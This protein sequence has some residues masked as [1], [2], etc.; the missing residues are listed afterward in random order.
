MKTFSVLVATVALAGVLTNARATDA[1]NQLAVRATSGNSAVADAAVAQLRTLG[2]RGVDLMAAA[3]PERVNEASHRAVLDRVCRQKDCYASR[4]FWYTDFDE[5]KAA[6]KASGKPIL[7][8]HLLGN[9]DEELSC[10]NSRFF[11]TT[12][13]SSQS[14]AGYMRD[15]FILHWQSV[16]PAPKV[17]VDF[18]DGRTLTQTITGN[19]IHYFLD[20][21]GRPLDAL[22]GLY[23]PAAFL[24]NLQRIHSMAADYI[25]QASEDR[26]QFA[27][28]Y[29][30]RE[31]TRITQELGK[32]LMRV[33]Q[34]NSKENPSARDASKLA[35][36]KFIGELPLLSAFNL[37]ENPVT[38]EEWERFAKHHAG[39]TPVV[40]DPASIEL[41][42]TK[43]SSPAAFGRLLRN[44]ER[45]VAEDTLRNEY[46][47]H[48]RLHEWLAADA[49]SIEALDERVYTQLFLTPPNDPWLGLLRD[50]TFVAIP[51]SGAV[52]RTLAR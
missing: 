12:L 52:T 2:Q 23:S 37:Q 45:T 32:D 5:A 18:G 51:N 10:A 44:L 36:T 20:A 40:F 41:M 50:D 19:S 11:R 25:A 48:V 6:S 21:D 28:S 27:R 33:R 14:I 34:P 15:H 24:D 35:M 7:S 3:R 31:W 8:L 30:T 47:L 43:T 46:D 13:Y 26:P 29:H 42:R 49:P 38:D 22:P 16:R 1:T 4:L 17:T 39:K 9:L